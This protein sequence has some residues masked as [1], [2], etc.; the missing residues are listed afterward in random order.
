MPPGCRR[1]P[2]AAVISTVP[3]V[4]TAQFEAEIE[5]CSTPIILDVFASWCGPCQMMAPEMTAVAEH[6]GDR[7]RVL[8]VDSDEEEEVA[9]ALQV[10]GLPTVMLIRDMSVVMRFEGALMAKDIVQVASEGA[11]LQYFSSDFSSS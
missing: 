7:L 8:K 9:T 3:Q 10:R 1:L 6:Y 5:D 2:R 11:P 4:D